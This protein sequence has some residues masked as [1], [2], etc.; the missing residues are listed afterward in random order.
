MALVRAYKDDLD[1]NRR[2]LREVQRALA[3]KGHLLTEVRILDM[4]IWS[5]KT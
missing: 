4:L 2:A 5:V 1:G 3:R